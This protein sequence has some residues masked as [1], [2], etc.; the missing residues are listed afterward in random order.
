MKLFFKSRGQLGVKQGADLA[1]LLIFEIESFKS[2]CGRASEVYDIA[3]R[4]DNLALVS[5]AGGCEL[6]LAHEIG[7]LLGLSHD[8]KL[9]GNKYF[10]YGHGKYL[11]GKTDRNEGTRTIMAE[12]HPSHENRINLF[13][14]P[15][16]GGHLDEKTDNSRV[17]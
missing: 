6:T 7:H 15:E 8:Y 10:T 12:Q 4:G 11:K 5:V 3:L 17:L 13:S 1:V 14:Y 9:P 2:L 16:M